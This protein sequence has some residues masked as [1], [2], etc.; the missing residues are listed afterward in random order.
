MAYYGLCRIN[1]LK[2]IKTN[3][4]HR[5]VNEEGEPYYTVI[6]EPPKYSTSDR[7]AHTTG[8]HQA[9]E[10]RKTGVEKFEFDLPTT[11]TPYVEV[12]IEYTPEAKR[13]DQMIKNANKRAIDNRSKKSSTKS[14]AKM[15]WQ[16][17]VRKW[18]QQSVFLIPIA[19][20][21]IAGVEQEQLA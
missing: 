8:P 14:Q 9:S 7:N 16:R 13:K 21:G 6:Y 15:L 17:G 2:K 5:N 10:S 1:D 3:D 12:M 4:F 19:T 20:Q 11:V 18:Q